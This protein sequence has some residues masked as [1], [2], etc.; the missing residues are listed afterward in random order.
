MKQSLQCQCDNVMELDLP[1]TINLDGEAQWLQAIHDG[2]FLSYSCERCGTTLRP[3]P[4]L[5]VNFRLF[6][7]PLFV[8]PE[9][10]R[11]AVI[12]GKLAVDTSCEIVVGIAEFIERVKI[13]EAELEPKAI[14]V[15]K[16]YLQSKAE[17]S[18]PESDLTVYFGT[19]VDEGL[20]FRIS[21]F[22]SGETGLLTIP[23]SKYQEIQGNLPALSKKLPFKALFSG[24]YQSYK[25]AA[26]LD[27]N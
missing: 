13:V 8:A 4:A 27:N 19:V 2:N 21:G 20:Q 9:D 12:R 22:A 14:E 1:E 23:R 24:Q 25:K 7:K 10:E 6:A 5:T 18:E 17:E 16:Y 11:I 3:E 26:F 15:L